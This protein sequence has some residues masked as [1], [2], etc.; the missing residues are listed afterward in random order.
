MDRISNVD[1]KEALT[2]IAKENTIHHLDKD[3]KISF[4]QMEMP[5]EPGDY[6][7]NSFIWISYPAGIEC[8]NEREAFQR[9]TS[10][11]NGVQYHGNGAEHEPKLVY[12]VDVG[13]FKD[14]KLYGDL[15]EIDIQEFAKLARTYECKSASMQIFYDDIRRKDKYEIMPLDEFKKRYPLDLPK[16]EHWRNL[17]ASFEELNNAI[18]KS[19]EMRM[20]GAQEVTLWQHTDKLNDKQLAFYANQLVNG[21]DKIKEPNSA[22]KQSFTASLDARASHNFN[23]VQLSRLLDKLPYENTAFAIHKG[24]DSM[25]I[26]VPK[27]EV[28]QLRQERMEEKNQQYRQLHKKPVSDIA[29]KAESKSEKPS[30]MAALDKG[31][32][33]S[34]AEFGGKAQP[35]INTPD[36]ITKKN[37]D[38]R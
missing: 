6:T 27:E 22:D 11:Y 14:G 20:T 35:D 13:D 33:K 18:S 31:E 21:L 4:E 32:K 36:K 8:Y 17:P 2:E 37:N 23:P 30:L 1:L 28:L 16:M 26:V 9:D 25:K 24:S 38:E 15:Y 19:W 29:D 3:L 5:T 7:D 10:A 12:A 34:K